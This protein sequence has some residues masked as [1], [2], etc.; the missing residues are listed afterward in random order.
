VDRNALLWT[1]VVFFGASIVF[2]TIR[3]ATKDE[4]VAVTLGLE[5]LA[6]LALVGAIVLIVRRRR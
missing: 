2:S 6:G 5:L 4:S 1:L 3:S